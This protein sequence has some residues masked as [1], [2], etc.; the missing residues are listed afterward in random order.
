MPELRKDWLTG[1]TVIIAENRAQRPNEF[2]QIS[3]T[4]EAASA[5]GQSV[6]ASVTSLPSCPFCVGNESQTPPSVYQ[7]NDQEGRWQIRVV[8]NMFPAVELQP[9]DEI[10]GPAI[11]AHEVIIESARHVHQMSA[12][13]A[14]E[15]CDVL[16]VY[17]QRLRYWH[18]DGR[19]RYGLLFKNQG[20]AAGAS[21]AH[22][23]SQLVTLPE[24]PPAVE[25]ELERADGECRQR[26]MCPYCRLCEQEQALADRIVL[27]R[28]GYIAFCPYASLQ[29]LEVWILP[30][31]HETWFE[32]SSNAD[33]PTQL[34]GVLQSL[35]NK[36]ETLVPAASFNMLLRTA[37]WQSNVE[38]CCHWRIELLPRFNPLAGLELAT[39]IHIN[40]VRPERAAARLRAN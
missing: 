4:G 22:L 29:P 23:H 2:A 24:L 36:L 39:G 19:F 21:L 11:G 20:Q 33:A 1:R 18:D 35:F 25:R 37:P 31:S 40:P 5:A 10:S 28:D 6:L 17:A 27:N 12:L 3:R 9:T 8:P 30:T 38:H 7:T 13:S 16:A 34:A 26:G 32:R 15:L 14:D